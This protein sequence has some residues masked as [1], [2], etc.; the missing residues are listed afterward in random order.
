MLNWAKNIE[1]SEVRK[2]ILDYSNQKQIDIQRVKKLLALSLHY[3]L[4]MGI[5][6]RYLGNNYTGE[7]RDIKNTI[8]ILKESKCDKQIVKD[9]ERTLLVGSPNLMNDSSTHENFLTYFRYKNHG[10]IDKNIDQVKKTT[11]KEDRDQ[12]VLPFP[13]WL[14]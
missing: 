7:Y 12:Y 3:N 4:D 14:A 9:L 11:N 6:I 5:V 2:T 1:F 13:N 8:E 10:T